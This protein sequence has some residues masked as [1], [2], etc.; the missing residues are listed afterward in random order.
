MFSLEREFTGSMD[1]V[2]GVTAKEVSALRICEAVHA[3]MTRVV[4]VEENERRRQRR[5]KRL[6]T[7]EPALFLAKT[8]SQKRILRL[9]W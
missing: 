2:K 3:E 5:R 6:L 7:I 4:V 1:R 9:R 8:G